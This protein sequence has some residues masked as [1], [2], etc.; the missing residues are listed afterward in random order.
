MFEDRVED[1]PPARIRRGRACSFRTK[2]GQPCRA[3]AVHGSD[4]PA[5]SAHLR[6]SVCASAPWG[7]VPGPPRA[8]LGEGQG[9]RPGGRERLLAELFDDA[10]D[11]IPEAGFYSSSLSEEELADLVSYAE[12]ESLEDEIACA[13]IT[14]RR[15][16]GFLNR[17]RDS[18]SESE[19]LRA[20]ALLF[21]GARTIALLVREQR[22]LTGGDDS[23]L[24][25]IFDAALDVLS[26]EWG[27]EL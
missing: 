24:D 20:A 26:E 13:R 14:V 8:G 3:W 22:A 4:P 21:Q 23:R 5:C 16:L 7:Q 25:E 10:L 12:E 2:A 6:A 11:E 9:A 15:T 17:E 19:F 18:M 1:L 27:I